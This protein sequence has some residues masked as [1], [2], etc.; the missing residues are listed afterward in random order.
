M[1]RTR[2]SQL[3]SATVIT[4]R[5]LVINP[6]SRNALV[7]FKPT[8]GLTSRGGVIPESE[9]QDSVGTFGK[10]VRD[11]VYAFDA[12]Y[13][14]DPHDNY[15]AA[16]KGKTPEG[17][18]TQFLRKKDA[19]KC[20]TFGIPWMSYWRYADAEQLQVLTDIIKL[21][22]AAGATVINGTEITNYQEII[23]GDGWNWNWLPANQS[24]YTVVKVDFYNNINAYLSELTNTNMKTFADIMQY[25]YDND[26]SE[27]GYPWPRGNPAFYSGQD[28]FEASFATKGI[29]DETYKQALE[30]CQSSSRNG[31][32]DAL[33]HKG[34]KLNGLLVP[35]A[36]G[37]S[38]QQSAQ[39]GYPVVTIPAGVSSDSGMPF[40][41]AIL[42]TA[43]AET[44]L[45]K[46]ASAIEDV[47]QSSGGKF[48][49]TRPTWRGYL[50]RNIPVL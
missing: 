30:F 10:T 41:L 35:P 45:V 49:R 25:N 42:Q 29:K 14:I 20:A 15:T 21:V 46:W 9:H 3:C 47:I 12:I 1:V 5:A 18:Y 22:E 38:Y 40:G 13:G 24:E 43:W 27:G 11:A 34:K 37:Q 32:N 44:E 33:T 6:A 23:N 31:I 7:G 26:G 48:G 17:G 50:Q 36:V 39:A 4:N 16:Q 28:G 19:L 8:V 2:A